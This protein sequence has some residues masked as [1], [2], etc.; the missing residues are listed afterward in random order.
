[1]HLN[2]MMDAIPLYPKPYHPVKTGRLRDFS[3]SGWFEALHPH[4]ATRQVL[5]YR[6]RHLSALQP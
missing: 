2:I 4:T 6:F 5:F 3:D 1:M